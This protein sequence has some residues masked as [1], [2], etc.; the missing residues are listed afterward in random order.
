[1]KVAESIP[2]SWPW[3][4][5]SISMEKPRRSTHRWYIRTQHLGPVLRVRPSVFGVDLADRVE[6][7][8]LPGE[9]RPQLQLVELG[10]K[11]CDHGFEVACQGVVVFFTGQLVEVLG[12]DEPRL[13]RTPGGPRPPSARRTPW[14]QPAPWFGSSHRSW[15]DSSGSSSA[16][17]FRLV[18]MS[19][20][21]A[22][23]SSR[24]RRA[25]RSSEKSC[26]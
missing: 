3:F 10:R 2:A 19:R 21:S 15:R 25:R 6:A 14:S 26:I 22:A 20:Y 8:V 1:M 16:N 17:R 4:M 13:Q 5:S 23:S 9:Q 24:R 11:A 18:S 7:V 12:V